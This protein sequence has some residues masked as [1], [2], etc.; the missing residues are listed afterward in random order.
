MS[1]RLIEKKAV[2]VANTDERLRKLGDTWCEVDWASAHTDMVV[3]TAEVVDFREHRAA[4]RN[5][6]AA[7]VRPD[8]KIRKQMEEISGARYS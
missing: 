1:S 6:H 3:D 5:G 4:T 7:K 8:Y 2:L